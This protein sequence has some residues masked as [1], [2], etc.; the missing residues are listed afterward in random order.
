MDNPRSSTPFYQKRWFSW[1]W[2]A[3]LYLAGVFLWGYF[4]SWGRFSLNFHDWAQITGPRLAFLKD[5]LVKG[6]LPLHISNPSALGSITDRFLAIPDQ[7]LSPQFILLHIL[8]VGVFVT[9][10]VLLMY[11]LG[12]GGLLWLRRKFSLSPFAF[13]IL[14]FLFN[15][16]GHILAHFAVGHATWGGFFLFPWFAILVFQ[17]VEGQRGWIWITK[18]ALL[19]FVIFLQGSYHQFV[20]A[21]IFLVLLAVA[22]REYFLTAA[23]GA[24]FAVLLSLVRILPAAGLVGTFTNEFYSGYIT[25][26]DLWRSLVTILPTEPKTTSDLIATPLSYWEVNLYAG[27]AGALFLLY[28]GVWRWLS[29]H[30]VYSDYQRLALP[31]LGLVVISMGQIFSFI[32]LVPIPLLEGERVS[33]RI[34]SL[35]FVFIL[36]FA[37]I[38]FQVWLD[39]PQRITSLI[40]IIISTTIVISLNDLWENFKVWRVATAALTFK[41]KIF[42][43]RA[44]MVA[45]HPDPDYYELLLVGAI[46]SMVSLGVLILLS[47]RSYRRI[48]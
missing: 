2:L 33:T 42:D 19:L 36:I 20:W 46:L 37:V 18:M 15:F 21:L 4:F 31:V 14:F 6:L 32:R 22:K 40:Y 28:F 5:A 35:P 23:G 38:H 16:N 1:V 17:L 26:A 11:S 29:D 12:F 3:V 7:I 25:L 45:N 13:I 10:H 34:I 9:G 39:R 47:W 30:S 8:P 24:L 44:W 41:E 48:A 27:L 43:P